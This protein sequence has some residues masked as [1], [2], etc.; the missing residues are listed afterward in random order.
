MADYVALR[1]VTSFNNLYLIGS[2]ILSAIKADL[3]TIHEY[4]RLRN[5]KQLSTLTTSFASSN[6]LKIAFLNTRSLNKHS[7]EISK[8][9][10]LLK[11][12]ILCLTET[13][14]MSEQDITRTNC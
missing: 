7:V 12:G 4:Q 10:R 14:L 2:F 3:K 11:A 5:E 9:N 6:F 13:N 8:D 1:R